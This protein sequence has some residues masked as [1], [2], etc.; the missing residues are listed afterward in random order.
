M[1]K[2]TIN[3]ALSV[4]KM[5]VERHNE[6]VSLRNENSAVRTSYRGMKGDTPE[7]VVP[8]YDIV[9][10]DT[11]ISNLSREMR[12]LDM[13]IKA[14]NAVTPVKDYE[15][16][17]SILGELVPAVGKSGR[18]PSGLCACCEGADG[19]CACCGKTGRESKKSKKNR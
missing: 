9:A 15:Y 2:L 12:K 4:K 1:E 8:V 7:T 16:D 18:G 11:I 13:A 14:T 5:L 3:E 19:P 10:M 6:L 17:D